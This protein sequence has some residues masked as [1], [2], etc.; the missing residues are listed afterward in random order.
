DNLA[1]GLPLRRFPLHLV[2]CTELPGHT[3]SCRIGTFSSSGEW[4]RASA[5]ASLRLFLKRSNMRASRVP[6]Q[7]PRRARIR[8]AAASARVASPWHQALQ[9]IESRG[10]VA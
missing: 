3:A 10:A 8:A 1:V 9:L 7:S 2:T 4:T 6:V 5:A